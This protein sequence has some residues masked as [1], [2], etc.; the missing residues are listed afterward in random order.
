MGGEAGVSEGDGGGEAGIPFGLGDAHE[1]VEFVAVEVWGE[2]GIG[3][4]ELDEGRG[5]GE[6]FGEGRAGDVDLG[7]DLGRGVVGRV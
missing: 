2:A 4:A 3:V 7:G 5:L 1:A 6:V